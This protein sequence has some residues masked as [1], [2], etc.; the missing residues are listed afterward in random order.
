MPA[1]ARAHVD[2][3][4]ER[5]GEG[6]SAAEADRAYVNE[7]FL[8][9]QGEG[10][11]SGVRQIFVRL[12]SCDTRCP[13][14]DTK[15]AQATTGSLSARIEGSP[16]GPSAGLQNPL[17]AS[18]VL[19]EVSRI[20]KDHGP[21]EWISL[22]GGEP[23]IW[24][25]F[26]GDLCP[27]LRQEGFMVQLETNSHHPETLKDVLPFLDLVSAD[28]KLPFADFEVQKST[29]V[30]FLS[31]ARSLARDR[32]P[33]GAWL[34][35]PGVQV[36]VVVTATITDAEVVEACRLVAGVDP[37]IPLILQPLTPV[38]GVV[39]VPDPGQLLR[40]QA[41]GLRHLRDVRVMPQI[42]KTLRAR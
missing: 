15:R 7:V 19:R 31:I 26:L 32:D 28:I 37:C 11:L 42:H 13:W 36:K 40:Q 16:G 41:L 30:E 33:A 22:T 29:Y 14:C 1:S 39:T 23:T 4:A 27:M 9:F 2:E 38:E 12:V 24:R 10:L 17:G 21:V 6:R 20:R 34:Q 18:E 5:G 3:G 35:W 25:R 8:S